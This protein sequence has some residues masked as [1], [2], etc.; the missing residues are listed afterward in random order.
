MQNHSMAFLLQMRGATLN[1][2]WQS[3]TI[4]VPTNT[5]DEVAYAL[6]SSS[7]IRFLG[8]GCPICRKANFF[9]TDPWV[10]PLWGESGRLK[11]VYP[12]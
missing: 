12:F 10:N 6:E 4:R 3:L 2:T 8:I 7:F 11:K 5:D 9:Q 1:L